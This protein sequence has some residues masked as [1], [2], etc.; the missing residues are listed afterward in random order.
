MEIPRVRRVPTEDED[1]AVIRKIKLN[2][3]FMLG[4]R[5]LIIMDNGPGP[6]QLGLPT[7]VGGIQRVQIFIAGTE[8]TDC[9]NGDKSMVFGAGVSVGAQPLRLACQTIGR[10]RATFDLFDSNGSYTPQL[11][12][13]VLIQENGVR[14]FV[15]CI[16]QITP[17]IF[18][19]NNT[20]VV[21]H[22]Q[23]A[24]KSAIF[25]TA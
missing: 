22:I 14:L 23:A 7:L 10:W 21:Y 20:F 25:D 15:G 6:G 3:L 8:V 17:E 24:D 16:T 5:Q 9:T 11:G 12:Q 18:D 1:E 13:T 19:G 4:V 2:P